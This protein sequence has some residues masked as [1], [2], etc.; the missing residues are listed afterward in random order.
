MWIRVEAIEG[1]RILGV[2]D[3]EPVVLKSVRS[4]LGVHL[5]A[6]DVEDW[7]FKSGKTTCGRFTNPGTLDL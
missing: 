7:V 5:D 4:R 1:T 6:A 3:S 2:L